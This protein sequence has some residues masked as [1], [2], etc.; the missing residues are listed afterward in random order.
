[1]KF[2]G[3]LRKGSYYEGSRVINADRLAFDKLFLNMTPNVAVYNPATTHDLISAINTK[4]GLAL[5]TADIASTSLSGVTYPA[6]VT[7]TALTTSQFYSGSFSLTVKLPGVNLSTLITNRL[8]GALVDPITKYTGYQN[9]EW[10]TYHL[11]FTPRTTDEM[12]IL[13]G[14][15][16]NTGL[17]WEPGS[18]TAVSILAFASLLNAPVNR[19]WVTAGT[20]PYNLYKGKVLYH[21]L[22]TGYAGAN[23]EFEKVLVFQLN[24]SYGNTVR[25]NM[26]IHYNSW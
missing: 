2:S 18:F 14:G 7:I 8:L 6:T 20:A 11:D 21:G 13:T 9:A 24:T 15:L 19:G 26:W 22:A 5:T 25:G 3:G 23:T 10:L 4:Y 12:G 16:L 1:M 17:T